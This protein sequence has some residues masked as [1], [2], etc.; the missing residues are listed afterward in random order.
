MYATTRTKQQPTSYAPSER[1]AKALKLPNNTYWCIN[2]TSKRPHDRSAYHSKAP[3]LPLRLL[4]EPYSHCK[5]DTGPFTDDPTELSE[6]TVKTNLFEK[7][8]VDPCMPEE[9]LFLDRNSSLASYSQSRNGTTCGKDSL[10]KNDTRKR[11][12]GSKYTM[13][14]LSLSTKEPPLVEETSSTT[15]LPGLVEVTDVSSESSVSDSEPPLKQV[16]FGTVSVRTY[17]PTIGYARNHLAN[18][19]LSMDW[20]HSDQI[21]WSSCQDFEKDVLMSKQQ[22]P[23]RRLRRGFGVCRKLTALERF[24]RLSKVSGV[25]REV[26]HEMD[27]QRRNQVPPTAVDT[28]EVHDKMYVSSSSSV[29]YQVVDLDNHSQVAL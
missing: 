22:R 23:G 8:D 12:N 9:D 14:R 21:V 19:P 27:L 16:R 7:E 25:S 17:R 15:T 18:Y 5:T 11:A 13:Y 6:T 29:F 1:K 4:K 20:H 28:D 3:P 26:I 2:A 24:T 10:F